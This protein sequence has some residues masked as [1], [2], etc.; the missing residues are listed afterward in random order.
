M[1]PCQREINTSISRGLH[2]SR[3]SIFTLRLIGPK[4]KGKDGKDKLVKKLKNAIKE[5][6]KG[7]TSKA[8]DKLDSFKKELGKNKKIDAADKMS[9]KTMAD[10]IQAA[11]GQLP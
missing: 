1:R 3:D 2:E 6:D 5:N 8:D 10:E 11:L 7:K 4:E 9:L